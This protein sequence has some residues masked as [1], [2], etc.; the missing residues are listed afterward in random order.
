[1]L[2]WFL[3]LEVVAGAKESGIYKL[4]PSIRP[5][6]SQIGGAAVRLLAFGVGDLSLTSWSDYNQFALV[7]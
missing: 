6:E 4:N 1:M 2:D 7:A 3:V 5:S